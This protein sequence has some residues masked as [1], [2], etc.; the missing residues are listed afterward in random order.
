[1]SFS[2]NGLAS[3]LDTAQIIKD[4]MNIERIPY[5]NLETKKKN[6]QTEQGVFRAINTKL[7]TLETALSDLKLAATF[8]KNKGVFS[9]GSVATATVEGNAKAGSYSLTVER[10]AQKQIEGVTGLKGGEA[11][12]TQASFT[13][14]GE[15]INIQDDLGS[16]SSNKEAL[17]AL[18]KEINRDSAKYG[19]KASLISTGNN[20]YALSITAENGT[21][22]SFSFSDVDDLDSPNIESE[23]LQQGTDASVVID[24]VRINS[25]SNEIEIA[26]GV[27]I[28]LQAH[29]TSTL[30]IGRDVE[31][32]T[33]KVE[34]FVTAYNDLITVVRD[35][36]SKPADEELTNPLQG[37]STLKS[38]QNVLYN[39]FTQ[40]VRTNDGT[41][42]G[43]MEE[44]GLSIDKGVTS[45]KLMTGKITFDKT[46]FEKAL[47]TDPD[48]VTSVFN[49]QM[50]DIASKIGG[51]TSST[52]GI[53]T[54]KVTGYD[55]E[56]K[57]V[58]E[59]LS[60]MER[61]LEMKEARLKMQFNS[62]EVMLSSL[63]SE[64]DW[65][66]SQFESLLNSTKK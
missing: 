7:R 42:I 34:A 39:S 26:D 48:K 17:D 35:N 11:T 63:K 57:V 24:G 40:M 3:G 9:N 38:L 19:G 44:L 47:S 66:K 10:L 36:L 28:S 46:A 23:N 54:M 64:Q 37:D 61:K 22:V 31:F 55:A 2:I 18:V 13:I 65:L 62:M 56:I 16:F 50:I 20:E 5:T 21:D 41:F 45:P 25:S 32:I 29:G 30:T 33:K 15:T 58:D 60:N 49:N 1:M 27:K 12:L 53:L 43:F 4:M 51:Y 6:L 14:N 59:R 8:E 52:K